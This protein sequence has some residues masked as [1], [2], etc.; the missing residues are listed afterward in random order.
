[1]LSSSPCMTSTFEAKVFVVVDVAGVVIVVVVLDVVGL[2]KK[3]MSSF[4]FVD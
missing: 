2:F 4:F 1:M 3:F